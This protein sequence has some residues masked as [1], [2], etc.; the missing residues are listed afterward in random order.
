VCSAIY[1]VLAMLDFGHLNEL[2][3]GYLVGPRGEDQILQLWWIA[4][5][6]FAVTHFHNPLFTS[7]QNY[8]AG[9]NAGVNTSVLALGVVFSPIT[10]LFGAVVT[11]N[12]LLRLALA[13]SALSM[14]LVLRRWTQWWPAAFVGGLLYGFSA[15]MEVVGNGYLF[16]SFV[17]LPPLLFL[18]LHEALVRQRWKPTR[19]GALFGIVCTVQFFVSSEILASTL[20]MCAIAAFLYLYANRKSVTA[21]L[22]YMKRAGRRALV[23]GGL[24]LVV[25]VAFT[26]LGPESVLGPPNSAAALAAQHGDL[27]GPFIPASFERLTSAHLWSAWE[28]RLVN[29]SMMYLGLPLFVAVGVT[30][31]VLRRRGIVLM[32]GGLA[33]VA[34]ILSLGS[35][36]YV[37]GHDTHVPLPFVVLA[38]LPVTN[39]FLS[40][41]FSLFTV[42]LGA[43][44]VAI[45]MD[46]IHRR[47]LRSPWEGRSAAWKVGIA[48]LVPLLVALAVALPVLPRSTR[49]TTAADASGFFDSVGART[50]IPAG[51]VVLSYPYAGFPEFPASGFSY[52]STYQ[53]VNNAL[54]DQVDAHIRFRLIGGFDW[55]PDGGEAS[56]NPTQLYPA[57]VQSLFDLA[58]YGYGSHAQFAAVERADLTSDLR[59][60]ARRYRVGTVVVFPL[61]KHPA[62]VVSQVTKALGPPTHAA[63]TTVWY[64]V[65]HRLAVI[66]AS[67]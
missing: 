55:R 66:A 22:P 20:F 43:A 51:S 47:L 32:A 31:Y 29:A 19:V 25:P 35:V 9:F 57:S 11:W 48:T 37:G 30:V 34:F 44:I 8:P 6:Q 38:H 10:S 58:F 5:A 53:S 15:Y 23:V 1:V 26:F 45:G 27:L 46:E 52:S 14:C 56:A 13:V 65:Q 40:T 17:P 28:P 50:N 41:R 33:A 39:G 7:W 24:L 42:M 54:V 59:V 62:T 12:I 49:P 2:G 4:W 61:G 63:G 60:F 67:S 3:S 18:L 36:L 16:L 64:H 21:A